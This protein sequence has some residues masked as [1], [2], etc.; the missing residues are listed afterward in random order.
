MAARRE[1]KPRTF[2]H[3]HR[4][5]LDRAAEHFLRECYRRKKPARGKDFARSLDL[6]PEYISWL[7][8]QVLGESLQ[9]FLRKK[10]LDHAARLLR[11]TPLS[12]DEIAAR[13][14][15]GTRSTMRRWFMEAYGIGPAAYREHEK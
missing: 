7:A 6:T 4:Q 1:K 12:V 8:A 5:A 13:S 9:R 3:W 10:Q 11:R 14:G 15:F 2:T